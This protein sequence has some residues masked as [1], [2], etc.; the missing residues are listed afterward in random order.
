MTI[1]KS[2]ILK[3]DIEHIDETLDFLDDVEGEF[4]EDVRLLVPR[5]KEE[6]LYCKQNR[7]AE[8]NLL[9]RNVAVKNY[10]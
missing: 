1:N 2:A 8:I 6:L 3:L 10:D 4:N 9:T 7:I 5:I